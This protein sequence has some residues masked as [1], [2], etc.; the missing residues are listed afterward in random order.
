MLIEIGGGF[1]CFF[2]GGG[3][4]FHLYQSLIPEYTFFKSKFWSMN[5]FFKRGVDE[6]SKGW[7]WSTR[8]NLTGRTPGDTKTLTK[9]EILDFFK[10]K[11][12]SRKCRLKGFPK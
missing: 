3:R 5:E 2:F 6:F 4:F 12:L 11:C 1:P 9:F 10:V 7:G 8:R